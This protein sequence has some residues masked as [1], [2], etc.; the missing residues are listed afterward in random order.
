[1]PKASDR[2]QRILEAL[3]HMLETQ[4]GSRIT[5]AKLAVEVGVSEAALYRHFPSKA[6]MYE[7]L[8]DFI[9]ESIFS[10]VTRILAEEKQT[11]RRCEVLMTMLLAFAERNPGLCRI[12]TGEALSGE[13]DYLRVRVFKF[14]D[15][16]EVQLKQILRES[17]VRKDIRVVVDM[18]VAANLILSV[19]DGKIAQYVRSDFRSKP[20]LG[21][22]QQWDSLKYGLFEAVA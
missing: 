9:E 19:A 5:T 8:I 4:P 11:T 18:G 3:T 16:I 14:F 7:G 6:K 20:T 17:D 12:L 13:T 1:M 2:K 15:R 21:W 10:R 22:D